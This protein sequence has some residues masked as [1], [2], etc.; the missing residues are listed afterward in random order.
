MAWKTYL[1]LLLLICSTAIV[2]SAP[3]TCRSCK[4]SCHQNNG[5]TSANDGVI[6]FDTGA[7]NRTK[8]ESFIEQRSCSSRFQLEMV[9]IPLSIAMIPVGLCALLLCVCFCGPKDSRGKLPD[10]FLGK[11][12]SRD[13]GDDQDSELEYKDGCV[14]RKDSKKTRF[15]TN[16]A[17]I[18]A[19]RV[20]MDVVEDASVNTQELPSEAVEGQQ[21]GSGD[22]SSVNSPQ[23]Q[24]S[25]KRTRFDDNVSIMGQDSIDQQESPVANNERKISE[26]GAARKMSWLSKLGRSKKVSTDVETTNDARHEEPTAEEKTTST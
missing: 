4:G 10:N 20:S 11:K 9:L 12:L 8:R 1:P 13:H 25:K 18:E 5:T 19:R 26:A 15:S 2:L 22:E 23:R 14:Q 3:A 16:V 24:N 7:G 6:D 21:N 17:I